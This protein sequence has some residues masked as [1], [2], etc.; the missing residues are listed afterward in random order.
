MTLSEI[1]ESIADSFRDPDAL[2][3]DRPGTHDDLVRDYY[4]SL[5]HEGHCPEDVEIKVPT[6]KGSS[7]VGT[8]RVCEACR[9]LYER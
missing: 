1:A 8:I 4:F 7:R 9:Y 5:E 2:A 3:L 6:Y